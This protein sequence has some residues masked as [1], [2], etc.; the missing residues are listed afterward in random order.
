MICAMVSARL[1]ARPVADGRVLTAGASYVELLYDPAAPFEV[2][3]AEL[4][5]AAKE[6][7]FDRDLLAL[8]LH[9]E[10]AGVGDVRTRLVSD[11]LGARRSFFLLEVT[12]P[13]EPPLTWALKPDRVSEYLFQTYDLVP[14]GQ[15]ANF[16]DVDGT[17]HE[18]LG[19]GDAA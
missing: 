8:A 16:L 19:L 7:V 5:P 13:G 14:A 15:E 6:L 18:I 1:L 10:P 4:G 9:G 3:L 17:L 2:C 12:Q 11:L